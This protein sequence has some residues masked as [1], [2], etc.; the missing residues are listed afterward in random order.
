MIRVTVFNENYHEQI[1]EGIRKVYP[2]GIHGCIKT[3]LEKQED[4][5]VRT[6]TFDDPEHGLTEEVLSQTD[7]L[8][9]WSHAKQD[10]FSS[11]VALRIQKHVL[12]GMGFIPLHSAHFSKA[13]KLLLGTTMTLKWMH[14]DSER[15]FCTAP[16]HPI[17]YGIPELIE[18]PQEEMYGE[19]FDIP[20]PDEV[21]FTGWFKS[22]YVF[23]S[24]CTFTRG[25]GKIFYFQ[26]GHEEYP[27]YFDKNIQQIIINAVRWAYN[28]ERKTEPAECIAI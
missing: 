11:E 13:V 20:K 16:S 23:R 22:G 19:F 28:P 5:C 18:L 21:V 3:F 7:V 6:C 2:Q 26:P 25:F 14:G 12:A 24:G 8:I 27:V 9:Y 1:Y 17:A 4:F 15:L 10:E